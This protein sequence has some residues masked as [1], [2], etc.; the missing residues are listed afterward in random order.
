MMWKKGSG[1]STEEE[2]MSSEAW[3][4]TLLRHAEEELNERGGQ[5]TD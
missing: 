1:D 5:I 4:Q 2:D 3:L